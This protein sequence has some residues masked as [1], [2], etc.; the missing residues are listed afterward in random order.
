MD[1]V[2]GNWVNF[3]YSQNT[4]PCPPGYQQMKTASGKCACTF[5]QYSV[6]PMCN[7]NKS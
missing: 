5:P 6:S 3:S 4:T 7:L 2:S 1:T